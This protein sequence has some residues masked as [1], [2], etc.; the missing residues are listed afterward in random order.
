MRR[1]KEGRR[2]GGQ[3]EGRARG[4]EGRRGVREGRGQEGKG[5]REKDRGKRKGGEGEKCASLHK[6]NSVNETRQSKASTP[7]DNSSF[8]KRKR[9][10][11][12]GGI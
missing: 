9:R 6:C 11:A 7:E 10:A 5:G 8:L 1:W 2:K 12:S 4:G 3:E